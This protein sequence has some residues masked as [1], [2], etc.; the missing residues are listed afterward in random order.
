MPTATPLGTIRSLSYFLPV[1]EELRRQPP[2]EGYLDYLRAARTDR[3]KPGRHTGDRPENDV[4][5]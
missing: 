2:P 4:F 3:T 5:S 1:I